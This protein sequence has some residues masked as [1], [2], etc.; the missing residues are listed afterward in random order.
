MEEEVKKK[1]EAAK[2]QE[3]EVIQKTEEFSRKPSK[4]ETERMKWM[5]LAVQNF[6]EDLSRL[7][8][9][10]YNKYIWFL[11]NLLMPL[12]ALHQMFKSKEDLLI[13]IMLSLIDKLKWIWI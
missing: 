3:D 1:M 9:L 12:K 11:K 13:R 4:G 7:S 2:W 8:I 5:Q 10:A 6:V